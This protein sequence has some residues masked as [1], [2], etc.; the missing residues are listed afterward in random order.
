M[1]LRRLYI[2]FAAA[3]AVLLCAGC[4]GSTDD[5]TTSSDA[6][7]EQSEQSD[8]SE[9]SEQSE[10]SEQSDRSDQSEQSGQSE[11]S[12]EIE[13]TSEIQEIRDRGY[14][15]VACTDDVP[16]FGYYNEET[17]TYEGGEIDLAYY[18]AAK[19]FDVSCEEAEEDGLVQ[20]QPVEA[21]QRE[22]VLTDGEADYVIATYTITE[23]RA[24][25]VDFSD[26]YY[27]SEIG[28]MINKTD[29]DEEYLDEPDIDSV[30]DL[31]GEIIGVISGSTTRDDFLSYIQ[32]CGISVNPVFFEY[33]AYDDLDQALTQGD[34]DVFCVDVSILDDYLTDAR[35]ILSDRFAAQDYGVAAQQGRD[36]LIEAANAVIAELEYNEVDLFQ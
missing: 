22:Q 17:G 7:A 6:A 4:T 16:G 15:I 2:G 20:F 26:S 5:I 19:V 25:Q 23:E 32:L 33:S 14:L 9:R 31:D 36:G 30:A 12:F 1:R 21:S 27:T 34:I 8:Q 35:T 18:I 24:E 28:L 13:I 10:Q 11:Q 29:V 3:A